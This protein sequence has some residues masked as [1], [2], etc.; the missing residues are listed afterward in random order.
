[1][2]GRAE[3]FLIIRQYRNFLTERWPCR[4]LLL[5]RMTTVV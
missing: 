4:K 3:A 5:R 1:M 2:E